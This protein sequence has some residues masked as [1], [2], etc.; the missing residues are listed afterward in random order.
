MKVLV[1]GSTGLIGSH[2]VKELINQKHEAI[3]LRRG[4]G[5]GGERNA[6]YI[7]GDVLSVESLVDA[8]RGCKQIYHAAGKFAYWGYEPDTFIKETEDGMRNV[9]K[10]ASVNKIKRVVFTSSSVTIGKSRTPRALTEKSKEL[11][12]DDLPTYIKAKI[13]QEQIAFEEGAK[14]KTEIVAV[15]PTVTLG[16]PDNNLTESNRMIV[17]YLKDPFKSTWIG[18]CNIV[19]VKDVAKAIVLAGT[20]G[21]AGERYLA[22]SENLTWQDV[23]GLISKLC[24]IGGPYV[25]AYHTSAFLV[26]AMQ[27]FLSFFTKEAPSSSRQQA[28]MVGNYYWYNSNKLRELGYKPMTGEKAMIEALSWLVTSTHIPSSL[29]ASLKLSDQIYKFRK[30]VAP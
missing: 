10:A 28:K 26:S 1:T 19:H 17:N 23:H 21:K 24:G 16:G 27:E 22:G 5:G 3:A 25:Q 12:A 18:G 8:S 15:C 7:I 20:S 4:P 11:L 2:I 14:H 13:S 9:I 29:R 30:T 6:E